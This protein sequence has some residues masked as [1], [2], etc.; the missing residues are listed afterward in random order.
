MSF[1]VP[2]LKIDCT[3]CI[4][5]STTHNLCEIPQNLTSFRDCKIRKLLLEKFHSLRSTLAFLCFMNK[6]TPLEESGQKG[7]SNC[8]CFWHAHWT[9][10][11]EQSSWSWL[12]TSRRSLFTSICTSICVNQ[13]QFYE[14]YLSHKH[15]GSGIKIMCASFYFRNQFDF[16]KVP[17]PRL[18]E[19]TQGLGK[20]TSFLPFSIDQ[21][22]LVT[23]LLSAFEF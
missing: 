6:W 18:P 15:F 10:W 5:I 23:V 8:S 21:K 7:C 14:F 1:I 19:K 16:V 4:C 17:I 9:G 13:S 11:S 3:L 20:I 2:N 22:C 12:I